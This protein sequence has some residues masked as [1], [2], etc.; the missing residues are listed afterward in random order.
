MFGALWFLSACEKI[1]FDKDP[2]NTP[3]NN[4]DELWS[5]VDEK[6]GLFEFKQVDW[7]SIR[8]VYRPKVTNNMDN[9]ALFKVLDNMLFTLRD[10]HVNLTSPFDVARNWQ[11][12]LDHPENFSWTM[13]ERNYLGVDHRITGPFRNKILSGNIGYVYLGSLGSS[14]N[15]ED[16][17]QLLRHMERTKGL[18]FDVRNN[19]GGSTESAQKIVSRFADKPRIVSLTYYKN[20]PAHDDFAAPRYDVITPPKE[21]RITYHEPVIMLINRSS[22]SATNDLAQWMSEFPNIRLMG[23]TTGGGSGIPIHGELPN[24][25]TY[26][27][28][29]TKTLSPDGVNIESGVPPD[30]TVEMDTTELAKGEDTI[31]ERALEE[32]R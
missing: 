3:L 13:I 6:Y 24:G 7:D 18:I 15:K 21:D 1:V 23:D 14:V 11:W 19:G 22:Y 17:D 12:Y 16:I 27:F 29:S 9:E 32:L 4:F 26:R 8:K 30:I 25:W 20:G 28:S 10:G 5:T 2:E 31:L